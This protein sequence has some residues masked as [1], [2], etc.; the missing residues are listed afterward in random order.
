MSFAI[1]L[2]NVNVFKTEIFFYSH[3]PDSYLK[4]K[5]LNDGN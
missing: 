3:Y 4:S 5:I 2:F 1:I